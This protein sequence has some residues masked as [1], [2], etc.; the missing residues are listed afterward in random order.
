MHKKTGLFLFLAGLGS[1]TQVHFVGSIALTELVFFATGPVLFLLNYR[2]LKQDGFLPLVWLTLL[3]CCGCLISSKVNNTPFV[4]MLK[5]LAFPVI[6]FM[7]AVSF[8]HLLRSNLGGLNLYLLGAFLSGIISI[9]IFQPETYT[10]RSG[11]VAEGEEAVQ[12]VVGYALFWSMKINEVLK[13][14]LVCWYMSTPT[15]YSIS[16]PIIGSFVSIVFS[17]ASGRAAAAV[18]IASVGLLYFGQKSRRRMKR[19]GRKIWWIFITAILVAVG[20]KEVYSIAAG[21]GYLGAKAQEK[22]EAQTQMGSGILDIL[23]SGRMEFFCGLQACI[24]HPILGMGPRAID[25]NGYAERFLKEH[26]N[27]EDY[28]YYLKH[29]ENVRKE[30][31]A[32][33]PV[34]AHS[35]VI[36]FWLYYGIFGLIFWIYVSW[37]MYKY[38]R[39][40]APAIPQWYGFMA[41][42]IPSMAWSILFNPPGFR[43]NG[44]LFIVALL[45]C[46]AVSERRIQLPIEMELEARKY[47]A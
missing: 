18:S 3:V 41:L 26:G 45:F 33:T 39:T 17:S 22:Y 23:M 10:A 29:L 8:H 34:P 42:S 4:F 1:A 43:L 30:G 35:H 15:I 2:K 40:Y 25:T 27:L 11:G 7:A 6:Y 46:K 12:A 19:Q 20:F 14:P 36:F 24:E 28:Q 5:G 44:I 38:L 31:F 13:L 16:A 32:G 21:H 37:L 47:D 9:F